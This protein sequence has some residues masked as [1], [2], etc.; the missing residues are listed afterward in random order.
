MADGQQLG[1][2]PGLDYEAPRLTF[3]GLVSCSAADHLKLVS[4]QLCK[5]P[6]KQKHICILIDALLI[7]LHIL[8]K[9]LNLS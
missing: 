1:F 4:V 7:Y 8:H 9:G 5:H 6:L 3:L 2:A